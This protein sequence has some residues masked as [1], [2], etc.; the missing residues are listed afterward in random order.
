MTQHL[1]TYGVRADAG[2]PFGCIDILST[3]ERSYLLEELNR[4]AA[5][6]PSER[7]IHE[8]FE[9]Q[10]QKAP[11]AVALVCE[12]ERLSYGE[13]NARANR[14]AHHLIA[15]G[16]KPG[17]RIAIVLDRS[18]ALVV[19]Q[20]AIL[21][22]GGVYVPI[23]RALPSARQ[24]LLIADCAARLVLCGDDLVEATI[25]VLVIEPLIVGTG[26]SSDPGLA[27]SAE[28]AAYVMYASGSTGL[29][30]GVVVPHRAVNRLVINSGYVK[31]DAGDRMAWAGNPAFDASTFEV[32]A[33]LLNGGCIIAIDAAT[34]RDPPSF[35]RA[36]EQYR[37]T[38]LFLTTAL[39]NQYTS[40]IAP[41]LAQLKY[42]LCG[43]ERGD[44]ASFLRLLKEQG[45]VRLIHCYGPTETTTFAT[46]WNCPADFD[47]S[48]VP[49]GRP[50]A[51]TRVYL[52]DGHGAPV[53]FGAVGELYIGGAGVARGYLNRPELTAERFIASPFVEGDRLYRTGDLGRYLPDGNIEFLGR[54][55][56]QVK[57]RG[58]RIEPGE[59]VAKLCE[60]AFVREAV[61]VA[62]QS[63]AGDRHL[64][65]Y[66]VCAPE[67]GAAETG[68][69]AGDRGGLAG[70]LR[71]HLSSRLPDYMVPAA[72]VPIAALPLTP[73]GKLDR[74]ALP[75]PPDE[76]Y[77][78]AAY[79]APQGTV[80]IALA[81]IWAELLGV[82]RIGRHDHFFELG[83]HSLLAVQMLSRALELG[84]SFSAA[85]LFQTPVL[86]ELASKVH[87][88]PQPSSRAVISVRSTGSQPPLFF[89]PSGFG[90]CSYVF[91]LV[92]EMDVDCPVY[93][94]PW[95]PFNDVCPPTLE[96]MAAEV[97]RTI[98]EI[99]PRGPYRFA[100]YS[101][102]AILA[103]AIAERLLSIDEAVSFM[104]FIDVGSPAD[105]SNASHINL[106]REFVF[107][108]CGISRDEYSEAFE[109]CTEH[110]SIS[111]LLEKAQQMGALPPDH[112]LH[113][114][115]SM[116]QRAAV[117]HRALQSYRVPPLP[118]EI[119]QFYASEPLISSGVPPDEQLH[120]KANSPTKGWDLVL[121]AAAIHAVPMPGNHT[122][123]VSNPEN[124]QVLARAIS[125]ALSGS[126]K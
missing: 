78:L 85:D 32:W 19:A 14:L 112:D 16:V 87:V 60:H 36:L 30:K 119:H 108:R 110:C 81:Q 92:A 51:N 71:A 7:C 97:I 122:T 50:I 123:M 11:E 56:D 65:A 9:A 26:C 45:P 20:L 106:A 21:K 117:F 23:D 48:V 120:R 93:A 126:L 84:L 83:G 121:D 114:D 103:Y 6:Y 47:G 74:N 96:A 89:V 113:G 46:V 79:E 42:L 102:G 2:Q 52:L 99:Q 49:I 27:L 34:V 86:K 57:I 100:G 1:Q 31:V 61:V 15:L 38:S 5:P 118:I 115:V 82:E 55:D 70:A 64:I 62:R 68:S 94:L 28:T 90:D 53:P 33:P 10:V 69:D 73:N 95:P 35:A 124:R 77:A 59:I 88:E 8:L 4:T 29:P 66:V 111:E 105:S 40:S 13:L 43:G 24:E 67:T 104:A 25:P 101:S 22:A 98:K 12:D 72:F 58:Y 54:N 18:A 75:A 44:L 17:D 91:G 125:R 37:V 76:A 107:E 109:G 80:E 41:A 63:R 116:Y 39:F 3:D